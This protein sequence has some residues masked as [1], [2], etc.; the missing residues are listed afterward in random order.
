MALLGERPRDTERHTPGQNSD[1]VERVAMGK[2][3]G[4]QCV[5]ALMEGCCLLLFG[6]QNHR[7]TT[8]TENDSIAGVL[9]VDAFD[10]LRLATDCDKR[11]FVDQVGKV[12]TRH[13]R[14][15]LG[16]RVHVDVRAHPLVAA[17][18][19][20]DCLTLAPLRQWNHDLT[21]EATGAQQRRI[22][23]VRAVGRSEDHDALGGL[24]AV[25]FCQHLVERLLPFVVA[26]AEASTTLAANRVD[27][28]NE[29]NGLAHALGLLEEVA[30]AAGADTD[31]HLHEV[32]TGDA[33]EADSGL[34]SDSAGEEGLAGAGR[35]DQQDAL[36]D[37]GANFLE[38]IR[39]SEEVDH[40]G[41][42]LLH[43]VITG[44]VVKRRRWA[45]G[46]VRLGFRLADRHDAA[47]LALRSALHPDEEGDD[48][49][50]RQ[51]DREQAQEPVAARRDELVVDV[52]SNEQGFVGL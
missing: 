10:L 14:C 11:C 1:L 20:E 18:D 16:H 25:H 3:G 37:P 17:V 8:G 47:H 24:K 49:G 22:E 28:V 9:E 2:H 40:L 26:S 33:Q 6:T 34:A 52:L 51:E 23:N 46:V 13:A 5:P 39:H 31:E 36:G 42:L 38:P 44:N 48:Q 43:A 12:G 4:E 21:V 29:D 27:L 45:A 32:G 19:F 30:N 50:N 15:G 7:L 35:T 41:D